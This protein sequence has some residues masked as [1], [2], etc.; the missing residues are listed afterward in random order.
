VFENQTFEAIMARLLAVVPDNLDKREGSFIWDALAPA[1]MEFTNAYLKL[2]EL[3]DKLDVEKL[4]GEE[5]ERFVYQRTGIQRKPATKA[6]AT[7]IISGQQGAIM[8]Q[9]ALVASST[10]N[11]IAQEEV[12][13]GESGQASA[14][15]ECEKEGS[16]GNVP[17]GAINQFPVSLPGLV[18]VYNPEPVTN[19]YDEEPDAELRKR[20]YDKLQRPGKAGNKHHYNQWAMEVVG[21]GDARVFPRWDG[22]LT[23]KVVI[24]DNNKQPADSEL[25]QKV[26]EHIE[27][28]RPFDADVTVAPADALAIDVEVE[29]VID[30]NY[31]PEQVEENI[32]EN[33]K[34]YLAEIAFSD[35]HDYV[36][37]A[38]I[39]SVI[40]ASDGV[41]D[42]SNLSVNSGTANIPVEEDEVAVM[43]TLT[44]VGGGD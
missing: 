39:G 30:S 2:Q 3:A 1:A 35:E 16:I 19:G 4:E 17:A 44:I 24:I 20:Y 8:P 33:I 26:Y 23:V 7:V 29:L 38:K 31:T 13:I 41:L 32:K 40:L 21:V 28:E 22:P 34:A 15:V 10:V 12:V 25:V 9:G 14:V 27:K 11:Y 36:S 37:Y 42:Y 6:T 5:L 43:G 18:D